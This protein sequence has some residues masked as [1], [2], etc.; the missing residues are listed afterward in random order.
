MWQNVSSI[1]W[2]NSE[3]S[4]PF[5]MQPISHYCNY[6]G[7]R[8]G[9]ARPGIVEEQSFKALNQ[10]AL[11]DDLCLAYMYGLVWPEHLSLFCQQQIRLLATHSPGW[12]NFLWLTIRRPLFTHNADAACGI[13]KV[14]VQQTGDFFWNTLDLH[15]NYVWKTFLT[16]LI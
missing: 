6:H 13:M 14:T 1:S 2:A 3:H 10:S 15:V 8:K 16:S 5:P 9:K 7:N 12:H 11:M 4:F